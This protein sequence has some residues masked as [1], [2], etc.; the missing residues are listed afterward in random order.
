MVANREAG[1]VA[2]YVSE[3]AAKFRDNVTISTAREDDDREQDYG[4]ADI[5]GAFFRD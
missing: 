4:I 2:D 5:A 1:V 3:K